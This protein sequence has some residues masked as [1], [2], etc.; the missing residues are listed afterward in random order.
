[1]Q[2]ATDQAHAAEIAAAVAKAVGDERAAAAQKASA[3]KVRGQMLNGKFH[4]IR[5]V[6]RWLYGASN[7]LVLMGLQVG[8]V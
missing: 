7:G 2:A 4:H 3:Q 5:R 1:M 8:H 6:R